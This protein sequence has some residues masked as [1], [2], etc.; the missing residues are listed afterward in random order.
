[1]KKILLA[2]FLSF[3]LALAVIAVVT[4]IYTQP[5]MKGYIDSKSAHPA[6]YPVDLNTPTVYCLGITSLDGNRAAAWTVSKRMYDS[7]NVGDMT[8]N[9]TNGKEGGL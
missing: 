3:I 8:G 1:M 2:S 5:P 9:P 4:I 6:Y 7:Y